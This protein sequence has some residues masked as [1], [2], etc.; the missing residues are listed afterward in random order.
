VAIAKKQPRYHD[1]GGISAKGRRECVAALEVRCLNS[2]LPLTASALLISW[3]RRGCLLSWAV[4]WQE[5]ERAYLLWKARQVAGAAASFAAP[6]VVEGRTRGEA[7]R[8]RVEAVPEELRGRA[9]AAGGGE[10]LPGV[11]VVAGRNRGGWQ[12]TALLEHAVQSLKPGV[13]EELVEMMG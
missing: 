6:P 12:R 3:L 5:A 2:A 7:K 13:F 8:R 4:G 9:A 11:S 10:G 1:D